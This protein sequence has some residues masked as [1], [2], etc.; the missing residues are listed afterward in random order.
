VHV[1]NKHETG[2]QDLTTIRANR[3]NVIVIG[4]GM[5]DA[6]MTEGDEN[7]L[8]IRI[9]DPRP[10]EIVNIELVRDKTFTRFDALLESGTLYP[11]LEV[12]DAIVAE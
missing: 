9:F 3:P 2:H 7:V 11:L 5:T 10:D 8:R 6:E 4:D 1:L 12:V